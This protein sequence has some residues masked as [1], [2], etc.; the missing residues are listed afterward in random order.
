MPIYS[1][2]LLFLLLRLRLLLQVLSS[3]EFSYGVEKAMTHC[4]FTIYP[5]VFVVFKHFLQQIYCFVR[6]SV[7]VFSVNEAVKGYF[8]KFTILFH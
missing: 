7:F 4:A 8:L 3:T 2:S 6:N 5:F 1:A